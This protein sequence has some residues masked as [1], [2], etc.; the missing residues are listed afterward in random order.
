MFTIYIQVTCWYDLVLRKFKEYAHLFLAEKSKHWQTLQDSTVYKQQ[1]KYCVTKPNFEHLLNLK[2]KHVK[3][4]SFV[5]SSGL[6][7][8]VV[9]R[10]SWARHQRRWECEVVMVV[11]LL[12]LDV[13]C[14]LIDQ[15]SVQIN[16]TLQVQLS[17][18]SF[19]HLAQI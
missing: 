19:N 8:W 9:E 1:Q 16:S 18:T 3:Y 10:I 6:H 12:L 17:V 13:E 5:K 11:V 7:S 4:H 2:K 15:W 14:G